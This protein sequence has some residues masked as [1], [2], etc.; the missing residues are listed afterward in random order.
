MVASL[1]AFT[2]G[3]NADYAQP[4]SP[5]GQTQMTNEQP[6]VRN[7]EGPDM[8]ITPNANMTNR[9]FVTGEALFWWAR[10][11][12]LEFAINDP[13]YSS[14]DAVFGDGRVLNPKTK[15][16]TGFRIGAGYVFKHDGWDLKTDWTYFQSRPKTYIGGNDCCGS[17]ED[18]CGCFS[19]SSSSSSSSLVSSVSSI[20]TVSSASLISSSA[21]AG[22][23]GCCSAECCS[24]DCSA[25][26]CFSGASE[27]W[28]GPTVPLYSDVPT[29]GTNL[30]VECAGAKWKVRLNMV[31]VEL[32]RAFMTSK[33]LA[34]RP[35]ISVRGAWTTEKYKVQYREFDNVQQPTTGLVEVARQ[36]VEFKNRTWG[37]GPR[38]GFDSRWTMG[39]GFSFYGNAAISL[40]YGSF[41]LKQSGFVDYSCT[42]TTP[43]D[44]QCEPV[45][46]KLHET[47]HLGQAITDLALGLMWEHTF[48]S[49]W[50]LAFN[51]G[52]DQ[53]M[54]FN[55]NQF[56]RVTR[57]GG[58]DGVTND[59]SHER[60]DLSFQG[61]SLGGRIDF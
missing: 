42:G 52:W 19:S 59:F 5:S 13:C 10:E 54:F 32:G 28:C 41:T 44:T 58:G 8:M 20:S 25:G 40:L 43:V 45:C 7:G 27:S 14:E 15:W 16:N 55:R 6:M 22:D 30:T 17:C 61:I 51:L 37:V 39:W 38:F 49:D 29:N 26:S 31:D 33:Y 57:P 9:F 23:C 2:A 1:V 56:W 24:S 53:H 48:K 3:V 12:G 36:H 60:G 4:N 46:G 47:Y 11:G 18:S 21:S 34:L 35:F 50:R